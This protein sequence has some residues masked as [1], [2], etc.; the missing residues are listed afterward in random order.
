[1]T[2]AEARPLAER[3]VRQAQEE[4]RAMQGGSLPSR[5]R[6]EDE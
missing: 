5:S 1:M 4:F 6:F 3:L 2:I